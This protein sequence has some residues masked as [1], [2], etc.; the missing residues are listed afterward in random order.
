MGTFEKFLDECGLEIM[1][2]G[3]MSARKELVGFSPIEVAVC[4]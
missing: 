2:G 3:I 4:R 1:N